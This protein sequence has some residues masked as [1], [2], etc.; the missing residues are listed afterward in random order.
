MDIFYSVSLLGRGV[1]ESSNKFK[2]FQ[3]FTFLSLH[4]TVPS[5]RSATHN[6]ESKWIQTV[7]NVT[8]DKVVEFQFTKIVV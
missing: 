7:T 5:L 3:A 1:S 8:I 4:P 2:S 6:P